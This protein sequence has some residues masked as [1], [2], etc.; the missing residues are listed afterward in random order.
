MKCFGVCVCVCECVCVCVYEKA[1]RS[2]E[3]E[4]RLTF[5]YFRNCQKLI[6]NQAQSFFE[7]PEAVL[8]APR[9]ILEG[10]SID[11]LKYKSR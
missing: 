11:F 8:E 2:D 6:K 1:K 7:P 3:K 9:S 4:P 10:Q 5:L